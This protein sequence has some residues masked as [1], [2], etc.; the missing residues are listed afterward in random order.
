[1][2]INARTV[3][4]VPDKGHPWIGGA[5]FAKT[6]TPRECV[7]TLA[8]SRE[9]SILSGQLNEGSVWK[10]HVRAEGSAESVPTTDEVLF[11]IDTYDLSCSRIH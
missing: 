5:S 11:V 7:A 6:R 1:M 3:G 8:G 4:L 2:E 9:P 10:T